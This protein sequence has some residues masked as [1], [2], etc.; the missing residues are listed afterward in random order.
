[1]FIFYCTSIYYWTASPHAVQVTNG[2]VT[3]SI[4]SRSKLSQ[5]S[6]DLPPKRTTHHSSLH[7]HYLPLGPNHDHV[8][9]ANFQVLSSCLLLHTFHLKSFFHT[10]E[11]DLLKT[12]IR[13]RH[14]TTYNFQWLSSALWVTVL[15]MA[16]KTLLIYLSNFISCY[17]HCFF[18]MLQHKWS[19]FYGLDSPSVFPHWVVDFSLPTALKRSQRSSHNG[20]SV[21]N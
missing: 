20:S 11:N 18:L 3:L 7:L 12:E 16:S 9:P 2:R 17:L 15:S 4:T 14:S 19:S 10:S 5:H 8:V 13:P 1:M 6:L 21:L